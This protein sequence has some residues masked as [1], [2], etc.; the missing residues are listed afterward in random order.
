MNYLEQFQDRFIGVM[1][2]EDCSS[3]LQKLIENPNDWHLYDTLKPMPD[4]THSAEDFI[5]KINS[6]KN[7]LINEHQERYCDI[8]YTN[9]LDNPSFVK[10]FHPNNLGKVC[11]S[12]DNHTLPQWMLSKEKPMDVVK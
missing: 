3:L 8:V 11:D 6:I 5:N 7:T 12:S 2:W 10:I 9:D 1:Q 4:A